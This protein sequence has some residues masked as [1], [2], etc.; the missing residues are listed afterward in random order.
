MSD[1]LAVSMP[2]SMAASLH[3]VSTYHICPIK[4][5]P[6]INAPPPFTEKLFT[7]HPLPAT[8]IQ[9]QNRIF[10]FL[11]IC[12]GLTELTYLPVC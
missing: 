12:Q 4:C 5:C 3:L 11:T 2:A 1:V 9:N 6:L 8:H 10:L 7:F